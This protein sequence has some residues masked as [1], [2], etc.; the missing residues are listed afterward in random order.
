[1]AE[2]ET[3][4]SASWLP[5]LAAGQLEALAGLPVARACGVT[6]ALAEDVRVLASG[7]VPR[8]RLTVAGW[9]AGARELREQARTRLPAGSVDW[10]ASAVDAHLLWYA[11]PDLPQDVR[12]EPPGPRLTSLLAGPG[13]PAVVLVVGAEDDWGGLGLDSV[14]G[15]C[16]NRTASWPAP[17][18][19]VPIRAVIPARFEDQPTRSGLG[20]L[21]RDALDRC[22]R[23]P[24]D[25]TDD[26]DGTD[27]DEPLSV[28]LT[29]LR[30]GSALR[31]LLRQPV[32][33]QP[34]AQPEGPRSPAEAWRR[35]HTL[36]ALPPAR[37]LHR[38]LATA[39]DRPSPSRVPI[40]S[41][42]T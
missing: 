35:C 14:A 10:T 9:A 11:V 15:W 2:P 1:M 39:A 32:P 24:D 38:R 42:S 30:L 34:P 31:L 7:G 41:T 8:L 16:R 29:R 26:A 17:W 19:S 4:G 22:P 28:R 40:D 37:R 12:R 36:A 27:A 33:A 20:P 25:S 21:L 5:A 3:G 6:P 18:P 23:H 13:A